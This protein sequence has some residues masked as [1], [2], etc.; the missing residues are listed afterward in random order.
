MI[1]DLKNP[2]HRRILLMLVISAVAYAI[3]SVAA[4]IVAV[5]IPVSIAL[6]STRVGFLA[7]ALCFLA[8][9]HDK[10]DLGFSRSGAVSWIYGACFA[11]VGLFLFL[12]YQ[13]HS[14]SNIFP[15]VE[16]GVLVFLFLD[17]IFHRRKLSSKE[18][19]LL[20]IGV[21]IVFFGTF[22]AESSGFRFQLSTLPY[23]LGIILAAGIG[24]YAMAN[25][26]NKITEGSKQ[27]AFVFA[28]L[29]VAITVLI[30]YHGPNV[31]SRY[32]TPFF[33]LG[34]VAGA[35]LCIAFSMEIKAVKHAMTGNEKKNVIFRNFIN[36]FTELDT[37]IVLLASVLIGSYT[38]DGLLGGGL[39][40]VG[41][42]ILGSIT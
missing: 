21:G 32:S 4:Y 14:L 35:L 23:A 2:K 8:I 31:L 9:E 15:L 40:I 13:S 38:Y 42:L 6:I 16:G 36:N 3:S 1:L 18:I 10:I 7:A 20:L 5:N 11:F 29:V 22:F 39:I 24:Y 27:L 28:G 19:V 12:A 26:T 30:L 37:V 25:K 34:I 17:L 41:V 33:L